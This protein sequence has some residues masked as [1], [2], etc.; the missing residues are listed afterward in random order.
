MSSEMLHVVTHAG[1]SNR[2]LVV[3]TSKVSINLAVFWCHQDSMSL[4][5]AMQPARPQPT[6]ISDRP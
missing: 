1:G 3:Y 4:T 6:I 5:L 2:D